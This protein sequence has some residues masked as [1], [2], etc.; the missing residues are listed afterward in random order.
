MT[1]HRYLSVIGIA[2]V[3]SW[4][5]WF[6][7]IN[8]LDP[9]TSLGLS[10]GLFY[11]SLLVALTCT[12][13][14]LGFYVRLWLNKNEVYHQHVHIAFRQGLLLTLITLGC[15]TFQILRTLTWWSGLLLIGIV[16]LV[17]LY[18]MSRDTL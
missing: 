17:E 4:I 5:A 7:V 10:L 14:I 3:V 13:T 2:G 9:V 1:Y 6:V 18:F 12:F 11:L 8:K 16:T 15:L